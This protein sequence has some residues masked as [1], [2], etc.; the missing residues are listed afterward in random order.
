MIF[1]STAVPFFICNS[2]K[3][4]LFTVDIQYIPYTILYSLSIYSIHHTLYCIH[5]RYTV[6]TIHYTVFTVDIQYTP[7]TILYSLSIYSIH[8]TL[9][10]IHCRYTVY[11]IHYT[12]FTVDH[13]TSRTSYFIVIIHNTVL[14]SACMMIDSEYSIV[15]GV[16]CIST[17]NTV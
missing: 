1:N 13:H 5:C 7:Y 16:Y 9:Y 15:Y 8:H 4:F 12:V 17:V 10:C 14:C 2:G 11:T 6:Y 3:P